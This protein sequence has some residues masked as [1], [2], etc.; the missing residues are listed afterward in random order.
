MVV[1]CRRWFKSLIFNCLSGGKLA[2]FPVKNCFYFIII[3]F[4]NFNDLVNSFNGFKYKDIVAHDFCSFFIQE[5]CRNDLVYGTCSF[6]YTS[7]KFSLEAYST[8]SLIC[9]C[10]SMDRIAVTKLPLVQRHLFLVLLGCFGSTAVNPV[11]L[12]SDYMEIITMPNNILM[13]NMNI[14]HVHNF[15]GAYFWCCDCDCCLTIWV[16]STGLCLCIFP[17]YWGV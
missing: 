16:V 14:L 10:S 3:I 17:L 9:C 1:H 13:W 7:H 4:F 6:Y 11:T 2:S 15:L 8:I 5:M 12:F